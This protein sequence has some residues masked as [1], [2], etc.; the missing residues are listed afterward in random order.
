MLREN[1]IRVLCTDAV[2]IRYAEVL[3]NTQL[4]LSATI[5]KLYSMVRNAQP[6]EL[7]EP[8]INACGQPII[9][10]IAQKLNCLEPVP[11]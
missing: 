2:I 3:E 6:W 5:Q 9:Q 8:A 11:T 4:T 1:S 7:G 10:D